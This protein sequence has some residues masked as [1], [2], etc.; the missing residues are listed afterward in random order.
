MSIG[1]LDEVSLRIFEESDI[2]KKIEWINNPENNTYL[3]YDIPLEYEKTLAWFRNKNNQIRMDCVIEYEGLPVG[4]IGLLAMD[5]AN[6]KVEI[7]LSMGE[8][9]YKGKGIA[10]KA[11]RILTKYAFETLKMHKVYFNTD[12][13]NIPA[14]RLFEKLGYQREGV[15][16]D[17]MIFKGEFIDRYRYAILNPAVSV[18]E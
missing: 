11:V 13:K 9:Q 7:Y 4:L 3:H 17:D 16:R 18:K 2:E 1:T 15:F 8:T 12:G 14:Q 10:T 5:R 6:K